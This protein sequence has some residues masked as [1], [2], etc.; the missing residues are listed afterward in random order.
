MVKMNRIR[1]LRLQNGWRQEDLAVRM[2]TKRQT[3]G[4]YET[5][6]RGLDDETICR[7]CD[8]FGCTAD[9]LLCRS[10]LPSAELTEEEAALLL[11]WRAADSHIKT[12]ILALL[13]P[14]RQEK[15]TSAS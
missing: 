3:I 2:N 13:E 10:V 4:N 12:G 5:G 7:L 11:A 1:E 9:Y 8:I 6:E 15:A 14:Y